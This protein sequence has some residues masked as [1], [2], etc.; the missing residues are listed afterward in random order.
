M[1]PSVDVSALVLVLAENALPALLICGQIAPRTGRTGLWGRF[2]RRN[3]HNQHESW[4]HD[5]PFLYSISY[6]KLKMTCTIHTCAKRHTTMRAQEQSSSQDSSS[7]AA[8]SHCFTFDDAPRRISI[9]IG[10][11]PPKYELPPRKQTCGKEYLC[12]WPSAPPWYR[13]GGPRPFRR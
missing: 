7:R 12:P 11:H 1:K 8:A 5:F 13:S 4:F 3:T 2:R 9:P 10:C 6:G